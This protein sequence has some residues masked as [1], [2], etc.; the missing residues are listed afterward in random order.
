MLFFNAKTTVAEGGKSVLTEITR[1][2]TKSFGMFARNGNQRSVAQA[3][4]AKGGAIFEGLLSGNQS[5]F[6]STLDTLDNDLLLNAQNAA[7]LNTHDVA[8]TVKDQALR[9]GVGSTAELAHGATLWATGIGNWGS[10]DHTAK[11]D[12][13]F[14]AAL[15]GAD[16]QVG[17]S[18]TLGAFFGAGTTDFDAGRDG[19]IDSYVS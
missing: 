13:E 17:G 7:V 1:D 19:K 10:A 16:I 8:K 11:V 15:V 9:R 18:T 3:L 14:Y 4:E 6:D 5:M 2:E 12:A